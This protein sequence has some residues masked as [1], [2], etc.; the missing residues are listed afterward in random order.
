MHV[1]DRWSAAEVAHLTDLE[2]LVY[3]S[4]LVGSDAGLV[5]WGGGN[6]SLKVFETDYRG[7]RCAVLRV[8]GTGSDLKAVVARDFPA[9]RMDDLL[10]LLEREQM[11]DEEMVEYLD[12]ALLEPQAV[13]PSIETLL[14]AFV[15]ARSVVHSHADAILALTD[16]ERRDEILREV[17]GEEVAIVPYLRPGFALSKIVGQVASTSQYKAVILLNHGLITWHDDPREAYRLHIEM[18][19]RAADYVEHAAKAQGSSRSVVTQWTGCA[20]AARDSSATCAD[21]A[22]TAEQDRAGSHAVR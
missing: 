11:S 7:R 16:N 8:K 9:V 20:K 22:R 12:H 1:E 15:P 3:Q 13:R 2:L 19:N 18:V 6:T 5:V 4:R 14:H 10:A 17:Y 21:A